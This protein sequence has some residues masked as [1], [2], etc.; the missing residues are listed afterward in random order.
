MNIFVARAEITKRDLAGVKSV[1]LPS[2]NALATPWYPLSSRAFMGKWRIF[3]LTGGN[4][5]LCRFD[6][7]F[8]VEKKFAIF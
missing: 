4:I 8:V 2:A 7:P 1:F 5:F 6:F 3:A